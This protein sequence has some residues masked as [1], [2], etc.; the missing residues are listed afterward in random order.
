MTEIIEGEAVEVEPTRAMVPAQ[1]GQVIVTDATPE[2]MLLRATAIA[3]ALSAMVEQ[4]GLYT[5]IQG[6]KYP[7]VEAWQTIGRM[8]NVVAREATAPT[9][10]AEGAWTAEVELVRLSDGMVIGNGSAMC[11]SKGDRPWDSRPAHQRRSMAVT[12]ATSR[13]FRQQYSWIMALAGY[14]PTPADEMP[15]TPDREDPGTTHEDGLVGTAEVGKGDADFELRQTPDGYALAFRLVQGRKG[16]KVVAFGPLAESLAAFRPVIEGKLV[17]VWGTF[18]DESF[19]KKEGGEVKT[20]TYQ[21][22][23]AERIGT[24]DG[25]IPASDS[26][27]TPPGVEVPEGSAEPVA[28]GQE[29]FDLSAEALA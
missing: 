26:G 12:R 29:A 17:T 10:D 3:T 4:Q 14:E 24:P 5:V 22:V 1:P 20:I 8:D 28:P 25:V 23:H 7:Q 21:V 2:A 9:V 19:D 11:G 18:H 27:A 16:Y 6:K 13:A 15:G